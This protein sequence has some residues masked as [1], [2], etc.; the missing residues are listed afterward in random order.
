MSLKENSK[1][2]KSLPVELD[3]K[4][5]THLPKMVWK[6]FDL[7]PKN[8][9]HAHLDLSELL[10]GQA[11][12][13]IHTELEYLNFLKLCSFIECLC[14]PIDEIQSLESQFH[15]RWNDE[16]KELFGLWLKLPT[17]FQL[18]T[19][20]KKLKF[21]DLRPLMRADLEAVIPF[22]EKLSR[23]Q[24][25]KSIGTEI[26]ERLCD[27]PQS[28]FKNLQ[29]LLEQTDVANWLETLKK[30]TF[31][32]TFEK[33]LQRI[34]KVKSW[35][36]PSRMKGEWKRQGDQAGLSIEIYSTNPNDFE[37]KIKDLTDFCNRWKNEL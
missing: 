3:S 18:W 34:Q 29:S 17:G 9:S 27:L 28:D 36:W 37:K 25:S 19:T 21:S 26:L 33:D 15:Y 8:E 13:S 30:L 22:L 20:E 12:E 31:P 4:W 35:P 1:T 16:A 2:Y 23:T 11:L 5:S 10:M 6:G 24:A 7:T 32:I 14:L